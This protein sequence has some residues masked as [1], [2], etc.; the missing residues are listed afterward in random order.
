MLKVDFTTMALAKL[1]PGSA[2]KPR[3]ELPPSGP[4]VGSRSKARH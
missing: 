4:L 3:P 2:P 1:D